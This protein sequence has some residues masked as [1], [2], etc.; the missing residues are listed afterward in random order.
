MNSSLPLSILRNWLKA[1]QKRLRA[2][3]GLPPLTEIARRSGVH[4]D[5]LY[6]LIQGDKINERSQ[7]AL[8]KAV[9]QIEEECSVK[10]RTKL[11][12]IQFIGDIPHLMFGVSQKIR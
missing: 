11:M 12:H 7:Y 5:T 10:Q 4:R 8:S 1:H 9:R 2:G 3:D 6:A